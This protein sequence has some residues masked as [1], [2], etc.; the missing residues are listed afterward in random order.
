[1]SRIERKSADPSNRHRPTT[2]RGFLAAAAELRRQNLTAH[3]VA[4]ALGLTKTA[5]LGLFWELDHEGAARYPTN[6]AQRPQP[7]EPTT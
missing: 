4:N 2:R 6:T 3:D 5:V 7:K 1:M